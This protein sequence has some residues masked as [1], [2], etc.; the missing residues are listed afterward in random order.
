M[1]CS[2]RKVLCDA[3]LPYIA[4]SIFP[5]ACFL[6]FMFNPPEFL[7]AVRHGHEPMPARLLAKAAAFTR[8]DLFLID[9]LI[10]GSVAALAR[11][12]SI[13]PAQIG[14]HLH[15]WS[16]NVA[17]GMIAGLLL[18]GVQALAIKGT[19]HAS[20]NAFVRFVQGGSVV[21]WIV[22]FILGAF[23]EELWIA[24]CIVAFDASR[25]P[26]AASVALTAIVFGAVHH[27][28][29]IGGATAV[30]LKG[31]ASA[32][33]FLWCG[34]LIPMFFFHLVGNLGSFYWALHRPRSS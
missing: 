28:Y 23:S 22:T 13:T 19:G 5:L 8:H 12:N 3:I 29:G 4:L 26:A 7:W 11:K 17:V 30:A 1:C 33:L 34:S 20:P 10:L 18:V 32:L 15:G 24:F 9:A 21:L 16:G 2:A 31:T 27:S 25:Y 14:L 6:G